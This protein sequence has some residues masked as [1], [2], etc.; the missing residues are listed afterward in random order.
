MSKTKK[1]ENI[2]RKEIAK[3]R[4]AKPFRLNEVIARLRQRGLPGTFAA[5][6]LRNKGELKQT[7]QRGFYLRG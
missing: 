3:H 6:N 1:A 2:L 4:R 5:W 7:N